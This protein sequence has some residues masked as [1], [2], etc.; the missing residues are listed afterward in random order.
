MVSDSKGFDA[1]IVDFSIIHSQKKQDLE[2]FM[3][4]ISLKEGQVVL[5]AMSG[6]GAVALEILDFAKIKGFS[7]EVFLLDESPVQIECS[8]QN[9]PSLKPNHFIESDVRKTPF[10]DAFFDTV[11]IRMGLHELPEQEQKNALKE[12]FRILKHGGKLI[13]WDLSFLD[14][15]TQKVFQELIRKKDELAGF[16]TLAEKRYFPRREELLEIF[17][18]TGFE[19]VSVAQKIVVPHCMRVREPELVSKDRLELIKRQGVLSKKD[20][21]ALKKTGKNRCDVLVSFAKKYMKTIPQEVKQQLHYSETKN[22]ILFAPNKETI[23]GY[24]K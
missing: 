4:I 12:V 24:K 17:K 10:S 15:K 23:I 5:D 13:A 2:K 19:N 7:L 21:T 16:E 11:V 22:D 1:R 18:T 8:K 14:S 9:L 20:E 6:Y 3:E